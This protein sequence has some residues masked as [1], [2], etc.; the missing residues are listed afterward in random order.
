MSV[1]LEK[2]GDYSI[3][4]CDCV[5]N[6]C[7]GASNKRNACPKNYFLKCIK[8]P[9]DCFAAALSTTNTIDLE[10]QISDYSLGYVY[11]RGNVS[12]FVNVSR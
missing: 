8:S 6:F 2:R 12:G 9:I 7:G 3:F 10:M 5:Q 1:I 11:T 4:S